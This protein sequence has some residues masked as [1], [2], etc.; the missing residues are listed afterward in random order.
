MG[1]GEQGRGGRFGET[2]RARLGES[3]AGL[4]ARLGNS[5]DKKGTRTRMGDWGTGR[6]RGIWG[7]RESKVRSEY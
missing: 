4:R 5:E 6:G 7:D 1:I 2:P 3:K